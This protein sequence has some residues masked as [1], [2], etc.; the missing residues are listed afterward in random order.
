VRGTTTFNRTELSRTTFSMTAFARM[1]NGITVFKLTKEH[2]LNHKIFF[3]LSV[4]LPDV[5]ALGGLRA[6]SGNE[7]L[8]QGP[9]L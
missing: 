3:L 5:M 1:T 8:V 9:V 2:C 7:K 6:P 4:I